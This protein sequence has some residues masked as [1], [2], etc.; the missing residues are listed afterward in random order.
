[1]VDAA[2]AILLLLAVCQAA[3]ALPA[4]T[5]EHGQPHSPDRVR[6]SV[7][8]SVAKAVLDPF[9][10]LGRLR[11]RGSDAHSDSVNVGAT[12]PFGIS[13]GISGSSSDAHSSAGGAA[14]ASSNAGGGGKPGH[15]GGAGSMASVGP[16]CG[17]YPSCH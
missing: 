15:Y 1:M 14:S 7:V 16:A 5:A 2:A 13:A 3:T 9:N 6:R 4:T 17:S 8:G 10:L 11:G 12:L